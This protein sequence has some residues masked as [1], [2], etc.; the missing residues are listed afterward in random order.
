MTIIQRWRAAKERIAQLT[1]E[2]IAAHAEAAAI[3]KERCG[4]DMHTSRVA[5]G[6]LIIDVWSGCSGWSGPSLTVKVGSWRGF[7]HPGGKLNRGVG[8]E[9]YDLTAEHVGCTIRQAEA[10]ADFMEEMSS[11]GR[12]ITLWE[13]EQT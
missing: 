8:S 13:Q 11:T 3:V 12:W 2:V 6:G 1:D 7:L 10:L 5:R 4:Q 9:L